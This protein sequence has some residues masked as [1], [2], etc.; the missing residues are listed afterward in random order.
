MVGPVATAAE[1]LGLGTLSERVEGIVVILE[2]ITGISGVFTSHSAP[3]ICG[4]A[5]QFAVEVVPIGVSYL[6]QELAGARHIKE[7][8]RLQPAQPEVSGF[9][10]GEHGAQELALLIAYVDGWQRLA[11]GDG[12]KVL[13][14]VLKGEDGGVEVRRSIARYRL[15]Q[16]AEG[17]G[18]VGREGD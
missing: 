9:S 18:R 6:R 12:K 15:G 2:D 10:L 1:M 7:A 13:K 17:E 4:S 14:G 11:L 16:R 8:L 5:V 3:N